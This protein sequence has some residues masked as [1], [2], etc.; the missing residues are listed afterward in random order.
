MLEKTLSG[1]IRLLTE[2]LTA[3]DPEA[4]GRAQAL[5]PQMRSLALALGEK[6]LWKLELAAL[7]SPIGL[8]TVPPS[9]VRRARQGGPLVD[10]EREMLAR[11]PLVGHS[12]LVNIPRLG[13][14]ADVIRYS[15][16]DYCGGGLPDNGVCRDALPMGARML[17]VLSGMA[18][19]E[20]G[21]LS[22]VGALSI[23]LRQEG[24]YDP[25]VLAAAHQAL[26]A[27]QKEAG[28]HRPSQAVT[29]RPAAPGPRPDRRRR[30][31][32]RAVAAGAGAS[33]LGNAA[34]PA[35]QLRRPDADQG[36]DPCGKGLLTRR[37][38]GP[39]GAPIVC[40]RP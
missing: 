24:R 40:Q 32:G 31:R 36:A 2:I 27:T 30:D 37:S 16:K 21:G 9:T 10:A 8:V 33:D 38:C 14:V 5:R 11:I 26:I 18:D 22:R 6:D 29:L 4:Y 1:T 20:A 23:M 7:L 35:A 28:P 34:G 25:R 3:V 12:L 19:L 17:K 15:G 39:A 13:P